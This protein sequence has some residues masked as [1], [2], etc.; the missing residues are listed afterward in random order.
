MYVMKIKELMI[1]NIVTV[2]SNLQVHKAVKL[3]NRNKI[4]CLVVVD[5]NQTTGILTKRDI[6]EKVVEKRKDPQKAKISEIMTENVIVGIPDMELADAANLMFEKKVKKLP[7]VDDGQLVGL[8]TLTDIARVT[9][10]NRETAQL[11]EKL[12]KM[13]LTKFL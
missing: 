3:M 8:V 10:V 4:G 12:S 11:L 9:S 13:N 5:D 6:L 2:P 1:K 7:V